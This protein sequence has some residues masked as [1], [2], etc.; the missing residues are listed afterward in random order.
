MLTLEDA[1]IILRNESVRLTPQRLMIAEVLMESC[2]HPTVERIHEIVLAKYPSISLATV[3]NTATLL[4]RYGLVHIIHGGK[5][6]LRLDPEM[7]PHAHTHCIHCGSVQNIPFMKE[8][9]LDKQALRGFA[10][11]QMEVSIFGL[12]PECKQA[13]QQEHAD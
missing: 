1:R 4:S 9:E 8:A 13:A 11:E 5:D 12:C 3:Y 2:D 7:T 6:G 10:C